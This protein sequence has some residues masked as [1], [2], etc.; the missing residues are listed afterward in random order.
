MPPRSEGTRI[1]EEVGTG[2][3]RLSKFKKFKLYETLVMRNMHGEVS[4]ETTGKHEYLYWK[5]IFLI[6]FI[7]QGPVAV[8]SISV[9]FER[10]TSTSLEA[11]SVGQT[12]PGG[13]IYR[14]RTRHLTRDLARNISTQFANL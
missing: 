3:L 6:N 14:I 8:L 10:Q 2:V 1:E 7:A 5:F 12:N 13:Q 11:S 9:H 4:L